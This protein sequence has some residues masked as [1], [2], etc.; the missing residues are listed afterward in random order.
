MSATEQHY[1]PVQVAKMWG[2]SR[3]TIQRLFAKE[4]DVIVIDRP[5]ELHKRGYCSMRITET[6]LRRVY[7]RLQKT[8]R[9]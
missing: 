5:E 9:L 7:A 6:A 3:W 4:P 2:L 1:T 8:K